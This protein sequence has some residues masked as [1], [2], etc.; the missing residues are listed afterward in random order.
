M[1]I[2]MN[3]TD[4]MLAA[5]AEG[6][7]SGNE[8]D[9]VRKYLVDNPSELQS[10]MMMMDEDFDLDFSRNQDDSHIQYKSKDDLNYSNNLRTKILMLNR[11]KG[12]KAIS[13]MTKNASP[14]HKK[15]FNSLLND[16]LDG[17][18]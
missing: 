7:I 1:N 14:N 10:V 5:Y 11:M 3:I 2:E 4:E 17:I 12:D 6:K 18:K 9:A 16:L 15:S 13:D 8:R